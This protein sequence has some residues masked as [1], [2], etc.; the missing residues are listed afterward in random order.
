MGILPFKV[1]Y[2]F[3]FTWIDISWPGSTSDYLVWITS[4]L[5][6]DL[7]TNHETNKMVDGMTLIG[8]NA[9]IKKIYMSVSVKGQQVGA[10]DA[11][12]FYLS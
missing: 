6:Q 9:C 1:K 12:N 11:Y 3:R 5:C 8:D 4:S 2:V 7:D 10:N